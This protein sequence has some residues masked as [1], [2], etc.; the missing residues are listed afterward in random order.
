MIP[1]GNG[2]LDTAAAAASRVA[3]WQGKLPKLSRD[4]ARYLAHPDWTARGGCGGPAGG[5]TVQA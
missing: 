1:I 2:V 5:F 3:G 4:R